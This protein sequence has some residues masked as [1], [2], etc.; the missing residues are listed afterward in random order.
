MKE[1]EKNIPLILLWEN[2]R[3]NVNKRKANFSIEDNV[4][5]PKTTETAYVNK[6]DV[7]TDAFTQREK[8]VSA[9]SENISKFVTDS[10]RFRKKS[11][12]KK[13]VDEYAQGEK[14]KIS[15]SDVVNRTHVDNIN[16][17]DIF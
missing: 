10:R 4:T 9:S 8:E 15:Y 5:S 2:Q 17:P 14:K 16:L 11:E 3:Q 13:K 7:D 1:K 12:A 6:R